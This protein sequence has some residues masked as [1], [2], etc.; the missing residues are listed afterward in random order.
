MNIIITENLG[1]VYGDGTQAL[2]DVNICC[3]SGK[4]YCA[5]GP[6]GAGKTT[7]VRILSTQLLPTSGSAYI[8][9]FD[10]VKEANRL[11]NRIVIV[12]QDVRPN[13]SMTAW[14]HVYWYL[15]SRGYSRLDAKNNAR[16]A[17]K[18]LELWDIKDKHSIM[19]SGGQMRRITVAMA[20]ATNADVMFLDEPTA[21]LDPIGRRHV[22]NALREMVRDG[23]TILLTTHHM[24]EAEMLADHVIMLNKGR[25]VI[26][27]TPSYLKSLVKHR[28][29]VIIEGEKS[30]V[31]EHFGET[32]RVGDRTIVYLSDE[33]RLEELVT[34]VANENLSVSIRP[35]DLED[36]FFKLMGEKIEMSS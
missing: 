33:E 16:A 21:G 9:G 29:K 26:S 24:D 2:K 31:Y 5:L 19:L 27:A 11:R 17:L 32:A 14:Q 25:I 7:L 18:L 22:W 30:D 13:A 4:L 36:V 15:L 20:L 1:K 28:F 10:V 3:E 8:L 34:D 6:N 35:I 12:P 23:R